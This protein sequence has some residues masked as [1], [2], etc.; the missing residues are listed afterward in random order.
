M[1]KELRKECNPSVVFR[2]TLMTGTDETFMN[3]E[4][5]KAECLCIHSS[6]CNRIIELLDKWQRESAIA[7]SELTKTLKSNT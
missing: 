4:R 2:D 1:K 5:V 3:H 6:T 7:V